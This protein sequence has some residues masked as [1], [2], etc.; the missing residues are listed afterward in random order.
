[1]DNFVVKNSYGIPVKICCAS[2]MHNQGMC[3]EFTRLCSKGSGKVKPSH[4]CIKWQLRPNLDKAG[5]G[6]GHIKKREY[7]NFVRDFEH[8]G[9]HHT[10][11]EE[12]QV[13]WEKEHGSIY[14]NNI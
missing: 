12:M 5:K 14:I 1:M 6:T 3:T 10:P 7:L 8:T 9:I 2:C 4:S 11:V 13:A